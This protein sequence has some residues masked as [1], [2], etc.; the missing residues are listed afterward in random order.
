MKKNSLKKKTAAWLAAL[1]VLL[2]SAEL[3]LTEHP[4]YA[5]TAET[6]T[7]F[8]TARDLE[9]GSSMAGTLSTSDNIRYYKFSLKEA[10]QLQLGVE[11]TR[12]S[13]LSCIYIKFYDA[14][15]TEIYSTYTYNNTFSL[16]PLY[17]TG[18]DYYM[19]LT[20]QDSSY[21]ETFSFK[22]NTD[23]LGESF[24]ET[25]DVNNNL[26]E[27]ASAISLKKTYKGVLAIND[28]IDY[29]KFQVPAAGPIKFNLTNAADDSL[30]Y[31]FYDQSLNQAYTDT[32]IRR[33]KASPSV[34]VKK[35]IYYLAIEKANVNRSVGSYTFSIDHMPQ[36]G[37]SGSN[38]GKVTVKQVKIKSVQNSARKKMTVKW[39]KVS[40]VSGYELWYSTNSNFKKGVVKKK[41][42]SSVTKKT[43][44]G[45]KKKKTY[46]VRIRAYK[47]VN[48]GKKYGKWS[49]KKSVVIRK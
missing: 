38:T 25:Q 37:T 46:Y 11:R 15:Q 33:S 47:N 36:G 10:N 49:S 35:G 43:Y 48:G 13:G 42:S 22:A 41:L 20:L 27:N 44:S 21:D 40:K 7:T 1:A 23:T 2:T 5:E 18:G 32:L 6:N 17:F 26:R 16:G 45:L 4:V 24:A 29:Y 12:E 34:S 14:S 30:R 9:F 31:T 28:D 39:N 3:P 8:A 19:T